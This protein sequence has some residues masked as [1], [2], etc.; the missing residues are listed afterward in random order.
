MA[1]IEDAQLQQLVNTAFS[2]G[3][4]E[5]LIGVTEQIEPGEDRDKIII[6]IGALIIKGNSEG[7]PI[8]NDT[9][10]KFQTELWEDYQRIAAAEEQAQAQ[11]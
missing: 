2:T 5:A 11:E 1:E 3:A 10:D 4:V 9:I 8:S 7:A 6:M